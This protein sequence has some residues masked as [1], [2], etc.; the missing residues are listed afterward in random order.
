MFLKLS[1]NVAQLRRFR[2]KE[3]KSNIH[4]KS[5]PVHSK[6]EA[7]MTK[8]ELS[9]TKLKWNSHTILINYS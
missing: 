5:E 1:S 9:M 4:L 3:M 7:G 8:R 2:E 6:L